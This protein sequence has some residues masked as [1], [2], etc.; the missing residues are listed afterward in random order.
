MCISISVDLFQEGPSPGL[1]LLFFSF[2]D[3]DPPTPLPCTC[4][5]CTSWLNADRGRGTANRRHSTA[6]CHRSTAAFFH[7]QPPSVAADQC[8]LAASFTTTNAVGSVF[9][10]LYSREGR[11]RSPSHFMD[12]EVESHDVWTKGLYKLLCQISV[13]S[14]SLRG[15]HNPRISMAICKGGTPLY[16]ALGL[17]M[18]GVA[19]LAVSGLLLVPSS[20]SGTPSWSRDVGGRVV[21]W[22]TEGVLYAVRVRCMY[23]GDFVRFPPLGGGGGGS[24]SNGPPPTGGGGAASAPQICTM[25]SQRKSA[26]APNKNFL[27][28]LWRLVFPMLSAPR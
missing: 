7:S 27:W 24:Q 6:N 12:C 1:S 9:L 10:F 28:H 20:P 16:T 19:R 17:C 2:E 4:T 5:L 18:S 21:V 23:W 22:P 14:P 11:N 8:P 15:S 13:A 26:L 25:V 3:P